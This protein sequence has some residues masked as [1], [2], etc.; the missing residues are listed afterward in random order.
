VD[1]ETTGIVVAPTNLALSEPEGSGTFTITLSSKPVAQVT[2]PLST[3]SVQCSVSP[4]EV[5]L[6]R[7]NWRNGASATV[8]A[9][10]DD[11]ADGEQA[12][13]V[14]TG[15]AS[16]S[17]A[18]YDRMTPDDVTV[19]VVDD[20]AAGIVVA[21]TGLTLSEL[22][23]SGTF[24]IT[25][26]SEPI[27]T[28]VVSITADGQ[29]TV[30]PTQLAFTGH[31]WS[32]EQPV[33]VVAVD[34]DVA[35]GKH[36]SSIRH[37]VSSLDENYAGVAIGNVTAEITDNDTTGVVVVPT[38]VQVLEGGALQSYQV[39]LTSQPTVSVTISAIADQHIMVSPTLLTFTE[40]EWNVPQTVTVMAVDDEVT[41]GPLT[42]TI[43]HISS[44]D[45]GGYLGASISNVTARV[46][47]NDVPS[48]VVPPPA[49]TTGIRPMATVQAM[50]ARQ[51]SETSSETTESETPAKTT[52]RPIRVSPE[53]IFVV[54]LAIAAGI[55]ELAYARASR[56]LR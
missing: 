39:V 46:T 9:A 14:Q 35:E 10:D 53:L 43:S 52:K 49:T 32:V 1:D 12:C 24:T 6:D 47:D 45:D 21:P 7:D 28:V 22:E 5:T 51:L 34:D 54:I 30:S 11:V 2:I 38:E 48:E 55:I 29:T 18:D 36:R 17:G 50:L 26:S 8:L 15:A 41:M 13:L 44:S 40:L 42:S 27:D 56:D 19:T 4:P 20:D 33:V 16:S 3:S 31:N 23:G 25:L 37:A